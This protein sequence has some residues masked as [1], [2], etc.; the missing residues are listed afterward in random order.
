MLEKN[1][2]GF[3]TN[4]KCAIVINRGWLPAAYRDKRSRPQEVNQLQLVKV[5]GHWRAGKNIH[6]YKI[7]NNPNNNEWHNLALED[8]GIFWD[9]PNFNEQKYYYFQ[10]VEVKGNAMEGLQN[11]AT[12]VEPYTQDEVIDDHY[13]WRTS[14]RTNQ[15]AYRALG[16]ISLFSAFVVSL[17]I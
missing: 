6:D 15:L 10:C 3:F 16:G 11:C 4:D 13:Q 1:K 5:T 7:P 12:P 14:E 8:I 2:K 17:C 9:L